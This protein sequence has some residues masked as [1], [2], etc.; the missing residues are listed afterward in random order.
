MGRSAQWHRCSLPGQTWWDHTLMSGCIG[1][2][3]LWSSWWTHQ[4]HRL[5]MMTRSFK[6][7]AYFTTLASFKPQ[8]SLRESLA[9][10][11]SPLLQAML[12]SWV[13]ITTGGLTLW[14]RRCWKVTP[15]A[16]AQISLAVLPFR[17]T[18]DIPD[19]Q[20]VQMELKDQPITVT[21]RNS[22]L[23]KHHRHSHTVEC[24]LHINMDYT[25]IISNFQKWLFHYVRSVG[26]SCCGGIFGKVIQLVPA[27]PASRHLWALLHTARLVICRRARDHKDDALN[28]LKVPIK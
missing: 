5:L 3:L 2:T 23:P 22:P 15:A 4:G 24:Y 19:E 17:Q 12:T 13:G 9:C 10:W 28:T 20:W 18:N 25:T 27:C 26:L 21:A 11:S 8:P 1:S 7:C 16:S 14:T 6:I